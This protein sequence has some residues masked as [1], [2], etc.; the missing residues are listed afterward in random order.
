MVV[1]RVSSQCRQE[2]QC[3]DQRRSLRPRNSIQRGAPWDQRAGRSACS[4]YAT[5]L[6]PCLALEAL[7]GKCHISLLQGAP[8][9]PAPP[10]WAAAVLCLASWSREK[11][12][13]ADSHCTHL[14]PGVHSPA[15]GLPGLFV[16]NLQ[17]VTKEQ[18]GCGFHSQVHYYRVIHLPLDSHVLTATGLSSQIFRQHETVKFHS[19][20]W[21]APTYTTSW[22]SL[23]DFMW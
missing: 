17:E 7:D 18:N 15:Q 23:R 8:R 3:G 1:P 12:K 22:F 13:L 2:R 20:H 11:A 16:G 21:S 9:R 10:S 5:H 19:C 14:S 6:K 4:A